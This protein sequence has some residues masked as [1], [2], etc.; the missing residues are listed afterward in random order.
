MAESKAHQKAKRQAAGAS[1]ATECPLGDGR[2][3]DA[4]TERRAT[5]VERSGSY[6]RLVAAAERL[7][8]SGRPQ[9][10]LMVP[11]WDMDAAADAMREVGISGSVK[12]LGG[13][14]RRSVRAAD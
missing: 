13:T 5:E 4:C 9:R 11:Q 10:I 3:L 12:N 7:A 2:R 6:D 14:R 8:D 1:G